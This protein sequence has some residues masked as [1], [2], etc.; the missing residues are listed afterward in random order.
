MRKRY[1]GFTLLELMITV[2]ILAII[3]SF[4]IPNYYQYALRSHRVEARQALQNISQRID[5]NY[6]IT[7]NYKIMS[8]GQ[9]LTDALLATWG[10]VYI[11]SAQ[12]AHYQISFVAGSV[13]ES[14]YTLRAQAIGAQAK[15]SDCLNFF[16]DQSGVKMASKTDNLPSMR[17]RD[18]MS[19]T[20]WSK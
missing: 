20:C 19:I 14:G 2:A 5:Q 18:P 9:Q 1:K 10:M 6:R 7:R 3:A 12:G 15:D 8:D 4:A 13:S 16:Y 11:P 17:G